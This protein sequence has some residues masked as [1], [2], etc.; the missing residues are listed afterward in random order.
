MTDTISKLVHSHTPLCGDISKIV[1]G[2]AIQQIT[3]FVVSDGHCYPWCANDDFMRT[4]G[5]KGVVYLPLFDGHLPTTYSDGCIM[6]SK[7]KY[8][9]WY[10]YE[11]RKL[12]YPYLPCKEWYNQ[13]LS[14]E[15]VCPWV[16]KP[17]SIL[18]RKTLH[19]QRKTLSSKRIVYG[20][21]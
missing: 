9:I 1:E 15:L 6:Y 12:L 7:H 11:E 13:L 21:C 18:I 19:E 4:S 5:N 17:L 3:Q 8:A 2:Y 16:Y 10:I 14:M 20:G